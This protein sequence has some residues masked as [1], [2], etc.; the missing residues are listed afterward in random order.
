M[1]KYKYRDKRTKIEAKICVEDKIA[2]TKTRG[3]DKEFTIKK[4]CQVK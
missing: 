1:L 4:R 3:E 2:T